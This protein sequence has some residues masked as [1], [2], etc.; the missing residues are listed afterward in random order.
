METIIFIL[1][2]PYYWQDTGTV[3][4]L[5]LDYFPKLCGSWPRHKI[6][7]VIT[8]EDKENIKT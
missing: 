8:K 6:A 1:Q 2:Y 5:E 4:R 7:I 3:I